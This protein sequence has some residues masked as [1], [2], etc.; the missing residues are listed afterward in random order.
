MYTYVPVYTEQWQ[1]IIKSI[2]TSTYWYVLVCTLSYSEFSRQGLAVSIATLIGSLLLLT[3]QTMRKWIPFPVQKT[4][5][6]W[7][8]GL[9][10]VKFMEG[11]EQQEHTGFNALH[12]AAWSAS[13]HAGFLRDLDTKRRKVS[14]YLSWC[15]TGMQWNTGIYQNIPVHTCTYQYI[16]V[17]TSTYLY[18]LATC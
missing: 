15:S 5:N 17:H 2:C 18:I 10:K 6:F 7:K 9:I 13:A 4:R 3:M 12:I 16:P 1:P 8:G 14:L 11:I